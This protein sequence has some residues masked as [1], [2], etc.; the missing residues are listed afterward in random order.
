MFFLKFNLAS[1]SN[2]DETDVILK[3]QGRQNA[4]TFLDQVNAAVDDN[5]KET[6]PNTILIEKQLPIQT[7]ATVPKSADMVTMVTTDETR[8]VEMHQEETDAWQIQK[9]IKD[10]KVAEREEHKRICDEDDLAAGLQPMRKK[11][12][13]EQMVELAESMHEY[14]QTSIELHFALL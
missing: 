14:C 10:A 3:K 4:K 1:Y 12:K 9:T 8:I 11:N 2:V 13:S 5:W 7:I 6:N